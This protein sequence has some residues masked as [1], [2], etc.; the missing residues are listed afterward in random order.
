[1]LDCIRRYR[2]D[3]SRTVITFKVGEIV[4]LNKLSELNIAKEA[5][6]NGNADVDNYDYEATGEKSCKS[7]T[8]NGA[9]KEK[10][11][12]KKQARTDLQDICYEKQQVGTTN[13]LKAQCECAGLGSDCS[14]GCV[15]GMKMSI[16]GGIS[17]EKTFRV[18]LC[19]LV[20]ASVLAMT[21]VAVICGMKKV[22]KW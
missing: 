1:M 22:F 9:L 19:D 11:R 8:E 14:C 18:L 2:S 4:C 6:E 3:P 7:F 20:G 13:A 16:K 21:G 17:C 10:R 15:P 5:V 12:D